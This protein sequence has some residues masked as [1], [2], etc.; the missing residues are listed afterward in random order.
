MRDVSNYILF[1]QAS[2][3]DIVFVWWDV[4]EKLAF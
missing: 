2:M 4:S 3:E 1:V